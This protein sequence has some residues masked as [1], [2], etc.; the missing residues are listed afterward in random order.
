MTNDTCKQLLY[1]CFEINTPE[2]IKRAG[3]GVSGFP[4]HVGGLGRRA[5]LLFVV[6]RQR[7]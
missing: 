1:A 2:Q 5:L 7:V 6:R 4:T 3:R